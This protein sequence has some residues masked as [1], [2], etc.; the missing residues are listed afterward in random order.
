ML[1]FPMVSSCSGW[2]SQEAR[3]GEEEEGMNERGVVLFQNDSTEAPNEFTIELD[4][5]SDK[6]TKRVI[7]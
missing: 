4:W 1:V 6:L 7:G 5:P 3:R 2:F